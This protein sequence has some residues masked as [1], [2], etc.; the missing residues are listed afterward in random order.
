ML[1]AQALCGGTGVDM[2]HAGATGAIPAGPAKGL[3]HKP[4]PAQ[5]PRARLSGALQV[6]SAAW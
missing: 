4:A 3:P 1:M 5:P 6:A 2:P